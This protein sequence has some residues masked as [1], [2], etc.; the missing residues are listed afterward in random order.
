MEGWTLNLANIPFAALFL[1]SSIPRAGNAYDPRVF[2]ILLQN[3]WWGLRARRRQTTLV[4]F[5][6]RA[7]KIAGD[8]TWLEISTNCVYAAML[9]IPLC[10]HETQK[11]SPVLWILQA[12]TKIILRSMHLTS[13]N[14]QPTENTLTGLHI[15]I[16][17]MKQ[18]DKELVGL[19]S[20]IEGR[21]SASDVG[22]STRLALNT[23]GNVVYGLPRT[24]KGHSTNIWGCISV[25]K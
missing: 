17:Q 22:Q 13:A 19:P 25:A 6:L 4:R 15:S 21:R 14:G 1:H 10:R 18:G 5:R 7:E 8:P 2:S 20:Q 12:G 16:P 23:N 9:R 3:I 24:R 11:S